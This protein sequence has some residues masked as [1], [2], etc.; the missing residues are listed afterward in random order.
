MTSPSIGY[1]THVDIGHLADL[2]RDHDIIVHVEAIPGTLVHKGRPL[3]RAIG[4]T[5]NSMT[6]C[7]APS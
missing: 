7:H 2:A 5:P 1:V 6:N 3:L 4:G